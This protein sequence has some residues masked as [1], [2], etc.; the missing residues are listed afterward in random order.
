MRLSSFPLLC[1]IALTLC[2]LGVLAQ[3]VPPREV[4]A[5]TPDGQAVEIFTLRNAHGVGARVMTW[6]ATLVKLTVPDRA[7]RF[8]DVT[9]GFDEPQRYLQP[10][11]FFG[12]IAGRYANR[13][14]KAQFAIDG[15]AYKL[16]ANDGAN[17][18]HGGVR[19][20]DKRVWKAEPLGLGAVRFS[21]SS[22]DGDEAYPGRLEVSVIYTLT[23]RNEL[24]LDYEARTDQPTVLNLTNHTYWNLA[25]GGDVLGHELELNATH[26]TP[27]DSALIPTGEVHEVVGTPLDFTHSK[28]VG[29]DLGALKGEGLPGGYDHNFVVDSAKP[30]ELS[31][32]AELR[33]PASG[34]TMRV[35]TTE[36]GIQ[37]YTGNGLNLAGKN[38]TTYGPHAGL[39]LETQHFPDS[40]NHPNFPS[41]V[42]RP[43]EAFRSTTVYEFLVK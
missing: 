41:T 14:A 9:L 19:G 6:G 3:E 13:I 1:A 8:V 21:L 20:F 26:F 22:S 36:P 33:D 5:R 34:R 32:A 2:P 4:A 18:I 25:G 31:L 42:L 29:R 23:D 40:P 39:C 35:F 16:A 28:T 15:H 38:G 37:L 12:S 43:G 30:G 10:H 24:R 11:P 27:A 7:G 17:H